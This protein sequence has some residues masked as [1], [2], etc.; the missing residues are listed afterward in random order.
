MQRVQSL[1]TGAQE[2]TAALLI[3]PFGAL[4]DGLSH[5]ICHP[6]GPAVTPFEEAATLGASIEAHFEWALRIDFEDPEATRRFWY[7]SEE[8]REPRL[9]DR[10]PEP[11]AERGS[12]RDIA[13]RVQALHGALGDTGD[14]RAFRAANPAHAPAIARVALADAHPCADIRKNLI[15]A[16][17]RPIDML[18]C[19]LAFFGATKFDPKSDRWTRVA[20]AQGAPLPEDLGTARADDWWLAGMMP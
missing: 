18:R 17:C 8:K 16:E 7:V 6:F 4:V 20:L 5:C 14:L 9:G 2:L 12:P 10:H 13:R 3:E 19:T 1:S 15:G 11:G